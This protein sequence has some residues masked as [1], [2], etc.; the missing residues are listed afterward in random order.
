MMIMSKDL[1]GNGSRE[2]AKS[3]SRYVRESVFLY[4]SEISFATF[5]KWLKI[6][7]FIIGL[8]RIV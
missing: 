2:I 8:R 6:V 4:I 1:T 3:F 5:L 7:I